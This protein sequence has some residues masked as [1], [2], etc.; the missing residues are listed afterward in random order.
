[1]ILS[2]LAKYKNTALLLVR[3]GLGIMFIMHGYPKI[4]GGVP[5]WEALGASMSYIGIDFFP[6]FWG[7]MAAVAEFF[8]GAFLILGFAF[9]PV[10]VMLI[11]TMIVATLTHL[12]RGESLMDSSHSIEDGIMF[13]GLLFLGPGKYSV[14]KK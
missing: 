4:A 11:I 1:M 5:K 6:V 3:I 14:D 12:G 9:R 8:G 7:L 2:G 13:L 10:C